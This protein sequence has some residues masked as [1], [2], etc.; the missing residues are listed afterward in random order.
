LHAPPFALAGA[1]HLALER[2][3]V[4]DQSEQKA[5]LLPEFSPVDAKSDWV[6]PEGRLAQ[7]HGE[8]ADSVGDVMDVLENPVAIACGSDRR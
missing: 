3:N 7:T 1:S 5:G 8:R 2:R 6:A 4:A